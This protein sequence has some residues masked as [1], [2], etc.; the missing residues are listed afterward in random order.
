[1]LLL[2]L[3]A[4]PSHPLTADLFGHHLWYPC[5]RVPGWL[6]PVGSPIYPPPDLKSGKEIKHLFPWFPSRFPQTGCC[7][8]LKVTAAF[9]VTSSMGCLT[10][11]VLSSP[12]RA[13]KLSQGKIL[14][15]LVS[16]SGTV[17]TADLTLCSQLYNRLHENKA[18]KTSSHLDCA[19]GFL[20]GPWLIQCLIRT[21]WEN[22]PWD[23]T[24]DRD[25]SWEALS[26]HS[27]ITHIRIQVKCGKR[28]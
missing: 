22:L 27:T 18:P 15:L 21:R 24:S 1:M 25:S 7:P 3:Q 4:P 8:P 20:L 26:C 13:C 9:K 19:F 16:V 23:H 11:W 28:V 17:P 2:P 14:G 12:S 10:F 5:P 6:R